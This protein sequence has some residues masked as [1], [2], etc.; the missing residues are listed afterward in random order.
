MAPPSIP[1]LRILRLVFPLTTFWV[2]PNHSVRPRFES[3]SNLFKFVWINHKFSMIQWYR[4]IW[5]SSFPQ[6]LVYER[7][8]V[9]P[10]LVLMFSRYLPSRFPPWQPDLPPFADP[11][12][13]FGFALQGP[14]CS[15]GYKP[16]SQIP[17][18]T[19]QPAPLVTIKWNWFQLIVYINFNCFHNLVAEIWCCQHLQL[20]QWWCTDG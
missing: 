12:T 14:G 8:W 1:F 13:S 7:W 20:Q 18:F 17:G 6:F 5:F 9:Y 19:V 4:D 15:E 16:V 2:C 10:L 3:F 11:P